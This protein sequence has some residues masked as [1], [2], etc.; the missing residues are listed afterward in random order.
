MTAK[1]SAQ[2]VIN[3]LPEQASWDDIMCELY[4]KQKIIENAGL[5]A[6]QPLMGREVP[7]AEPDNIQESL[8]RAVLESLVLKHNAKPAFVESVK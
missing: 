8:F 6:D 5:L 2:Q 7:E 3:Q 1:E 4:V